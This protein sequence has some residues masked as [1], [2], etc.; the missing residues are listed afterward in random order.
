MTACSDRQTTQGGE[1]IRRLLTFVVEWK[2][3]PCGLLDDADFVVGEAVELADELVDLAVGGV[4]LPLDLLAALG[5]LLGGEEVTESGTG[6][7][8]VGLTIPTVLASVLRMPSR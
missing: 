8:G 3:S 6:A 4:G 1:P 7:T 2:T 5:Q